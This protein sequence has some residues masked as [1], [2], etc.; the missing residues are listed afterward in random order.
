VLG[1]DDALLTTAFTNLHAARAMVRAANDWTAQEW[2]ARDPRLHGLIMVQSSVPEEAAA[3]IRRVGEDER[4]VGVALGANGLSTPFGH[5]VYHPIYAAACELD[6]PLVLQVGD[7]ATT[8]TS[9]PVA[10]GLPSTYGEYRALGMHAH[11]SHVAT[12]IIQ[13]VFERFPTLRLVLVGGGASWLPGYLWRL[14]YWHKAAQQ[15]APW[16]TRLPSDYFRD[17]IWVTT[18][19]LEVSPAPERLATVLGTLPWI[20][21]NLLYASGYPNRDAA[22]PS[23]VAARLPEAWHAGVFAG[24]AEACFRWPTR[25]G[26]ATA[27]R[28]EH[29]PSTDGERR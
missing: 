29:N 24:N 17:H 8:A 19:Q 27:A 12:M 5:L 4:M 11:M 23:E 16:L 15:S 26:A 21:R 10:G 2:L 13:G 28:S 7:S 3:E 1:Y 14:N 9:P 18:Y 22:E 6:L 25:A 20:D